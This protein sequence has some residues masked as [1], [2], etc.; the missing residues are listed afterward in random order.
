MDG[1]IIASDV[2]QRDKYLNIF[3]K[4]LTI[5]HQ[6]YPQISHQKKSP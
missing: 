4:Y 6:Y 2:G 5:P 3:R 1:K